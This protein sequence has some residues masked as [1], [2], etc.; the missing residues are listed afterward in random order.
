MGFYFR[1][2]YF[3]PLFSTTKKPSP[4]LIDRQF[5]CAG[6]C[7][8]QESASFEVGEVGKF[9]GNESERMNPW[10]GSHA[11]KQ[12]APGW[13]REMSAAN[14]PYLDFPR[15][16]QS[17]SLVEILCRT[18][19]EIGGGVFA[20]VCPAIPG[21]AE[22]LILFNSPATGATLGCPV[23]ELSAEL[24]RLKIAASDAAFGC[25]D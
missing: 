13:R 24:V 9:L 11:P 15:K 5:Y 25:E 3:L 7:F 14:V 16:E 6:S 21:R 22:K 1:L 12:S 19:V 4:I 23:S 17:T 10:R 2:P 18:M 20:G 8:R